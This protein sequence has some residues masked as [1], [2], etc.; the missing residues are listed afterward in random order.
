MTKLLIATGNAGKVREYRALLSD[1]GLELTWPGREQLNVVVDEVGDTYEENARL[2]AEAYAQASGLWALADDSGLEVDAL[3]GAPGIRSARFAG[4]GAQDQDRYLLLLEH[5]AG[6][7]PDARGARFR[8]VIAL[9]SPRGDVWLCEG[10]C[11]GV[12][13]TSPS[14]VGGFGYDPVFFI[15]ELGRT[16][17]ELCPEVKNRISHRAKA[18]QQVARHLGELRACG[19]LADA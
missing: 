6:T 5:L 19:E 17:G 16:M 4:E 8:C 10:T 3:G 2:K 13:A 7:P 18:T 15:P 9:A 14:G 11:E 12:I 1:T